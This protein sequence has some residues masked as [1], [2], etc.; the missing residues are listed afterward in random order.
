[1]VDADI[2]SSVERTLASEAQELVRLGKTIDHCAVAKCVR[3]LAEC[4]GRV[5]TAGV[6]TSGAAA[7]KIAHSLCCIERPAFFLFAGDAPHGGMGAVQPDDTVIAISKGG[8]TR[9]L[10]P[11]LSV[12]KKKGALVIGVTENPRSVVGKHSEIVLRVR[13]ER[14]P[15][16][17]NMLAT[18]STMAVV[19]VFDA[20][21]IA[22]ME[23]TGYTQEQFALIHPGGAVGERLLVTGVS[24]S[25]EAEL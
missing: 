2:S 4:R 23:Y 14:E 15:D 9:E 24:E 20:I 12:A 8:N 22:L 19:A 1:M 11:I 7:K 21:C 10:L 13:V 5:I 18:A 25:V 3:A 17:F 6:G 16:P